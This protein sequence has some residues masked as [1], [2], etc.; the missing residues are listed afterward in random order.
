MGFDTILE[1]DAIHV[2]SLLFIS[3]MFGV[4]VCMQESMFRA[5][6][7]FFVPFYSFL[8]MRIYSFIMTCFSNVLHH[9]QPPFLISEI[10]DKLTLLCSVG[11]CLSLFFSVQ[12]VGAK[13]F[14]CFITYLYSIVGYAFFGS[15]ATFILIVYDKLTE[16]SSRPFNS[17]ADY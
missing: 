3:P 6:F 4:C 17:I 8:L 11:F 5:Y 2:L 9:T 1:F 7:S 16:F 10:K 13:N 12:F 15:I 14:F